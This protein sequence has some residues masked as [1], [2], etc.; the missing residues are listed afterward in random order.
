MPPMQARGRFGTGGGEGYSEPP[1]ARGRAMRHDDAANEARGRAPAGLLHVDQRARLV[2]EARAERLC[3]V[4]PQ[5]VT[6][7]CLRATAVVKTADLLL[8]LVRHL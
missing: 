3:K 4:V 2:Q 5:L 6:G 8:V 1:K 7:A